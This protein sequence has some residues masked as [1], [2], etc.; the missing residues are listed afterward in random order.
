MF[1]AGKPSKW[2]VEQFGDDAADVAKYVVRGLISG[3]Q[4]ARKV[5]AAAR[6]E[7]VG[8]NRPFGSMWSARY[9]KF[10]DE[11]R[12]ADLPD[13]EVVK[14][15]GAS[16]QLCVVNGRVLI[17]F[18]HDT[19]LRKSIG[20]AKLDS[21][22]PRR[23]GQ[24][25]GVLPE[26]TLFDEL[27]LEASVA[28]EQEPDG[29]PTFGEVVAQATASNFT[30]VYVAY[31]ANADSHEIQA[32]WWGTPISLEHDGRLTWFPEQLDV[33]P[34]DDNMNNG[35]DTDLQAVDTNGD[36]PGFAQGDEPDLGITPKP[37]KDELPESEVD[38]MPPDAAAQDDE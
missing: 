26:L 11:L 15:K 1:S 24:E 14:P 30:V 4:S 37:R 25:S 19:S 10:V 32:A 33:S 21:L 31:V 28:N 12:L 17:P 9:Q 5:Q 16:Y 13:Y 7:G 23:I 36:A 34:A 3:Q 2:A 18:R 20:R 8:D 22:I 27:E 6:A 29:S 35:P 38:P